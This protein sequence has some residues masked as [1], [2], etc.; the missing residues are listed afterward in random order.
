MSSS[1]SWRRD[2]RF[3]VAMPPSEVVVTVIK[4]VGLCADCGSPDHTHRLDCPS[5]SAQFYGFTVHG[6]IVADSA[7]EA[8]GSGSPLVDAL[9]ALDFVTE[10]E[11][12]ITLTPETDE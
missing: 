10:A 7:G 8:E 3:A 11:V 4:P 6:K 5:A 12:W 2:A 1:W 9:F